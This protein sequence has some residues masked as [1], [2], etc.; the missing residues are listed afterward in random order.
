MY[1][2]KK[3]EKKYQII[4]FNVVFR[5]RKIIINLRY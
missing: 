5:L 3:S 4:V 2:M 1:L